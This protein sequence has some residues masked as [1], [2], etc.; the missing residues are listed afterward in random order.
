[1]TTEK[2]T[3]GKQLIEMYHATTPFL[4]QYP[5]E[6]ED[7]RWAELIISLFSGIGTEPA[8]S[9]HAVGLLKRLNLLKPKD[10]GRIGEGETLIIQRVLSE[11]GM[12]LQVSGPSA[13]ALLKLTRLVNA[14]WDGY[15]QR[16]LR[17]YG[18]KMVKELQGYLIRSG[19]EGE[20]SKRIATI[21]LQNVCNLPIL[22]EGDPDIK[23]FCSKFRLTESTLVNI[24]DGLGLNVCVA[25][26]LITI[27]YVSNGSTTQLNKRSSRSR[28]AKK[29][30][31]AG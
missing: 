15:I 7:D 18:A 1:M 29:T 3:A 9:K 10:L 28:V 16:F 21:W 6:F 11:A 20:Q 19:V 25:D 13:E 17:S 2:N 12:E 4:E 27:H 26:D 14:K 31:M 30:P 22:L 8:I 24:L 5:W 23:N